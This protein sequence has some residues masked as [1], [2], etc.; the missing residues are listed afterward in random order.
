V[1]EK[2]RIKKKNRAI[3]KSGFSVLFFRK[4]IQ[5]FSSSIS[6]FVRFN[7]IQM[8]FVAFLRIVFLSIISTIFFALIFAREAKF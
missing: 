2:S 4:K 7:K 5:H 6:F 3:Q 1:N 8:K